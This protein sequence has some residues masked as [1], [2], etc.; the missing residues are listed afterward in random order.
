M[1]RQQSQNSIFEPDDYGQPTEPLPRI[2]FPVQPT[3]TYPMGSLPVGG[4]T[5][6][7]PQVSAYPSPLDTPLPATYQPQVYPVLP[8]V[9][10]PA[11]SGK[12]RSPLPGLVG[13]CFVLVQLV[14]LARVVCMLLGITATRPW[15]SLLFAVSDFFVWPV[16][17]LAANINLS[18]LAGTQLLIYLEFLLIILAY[19]LFSRLLVRLLKVWL[20]D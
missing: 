17:W 14:L 19:G 5:V 2:V 20:N 15:F 3:S 10:Q 6:P 11:R 18:V 4:P 13:W 7:T 9:H 1:G 8:P 16:R 12:R